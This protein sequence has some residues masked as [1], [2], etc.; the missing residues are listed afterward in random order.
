MKLAPVAAAALAL[1]FLNLP[2]HTPHFPN[3]SGLALALNL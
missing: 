1:T 3:T 2:C